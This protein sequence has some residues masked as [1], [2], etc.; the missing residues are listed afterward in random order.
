MGQNVAIEH[1]AQL[2]AQC[3]TADPANQATQDG[4]RYGAKGDT[5]RA[6]KRTHRSARLAACER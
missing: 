3:A 4:T 1:F 5:D 2:G 6:G